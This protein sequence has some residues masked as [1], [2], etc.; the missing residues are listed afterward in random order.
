MRINVT[1]DDIKMGRK[2]NC[3]ECPVA[4]AIARDTN[5]YN[6]EVGGSYLILIDDYRFDNSGNCLGLREV[7]DFVWEF[8]NG[9]EVKPFSFEM[10]LDEGT[11]VNSL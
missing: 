10:P 5:S 2:D 1:D 8:D 6:V 11:R 4:L 7:F 9:L 3:R